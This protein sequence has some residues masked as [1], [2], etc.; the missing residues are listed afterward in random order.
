[1][2]LWELYAD[3]ERN[4]GNFKSL[5]AAYK[6]MVELKVVTPFII[7]SFANLLEENAYFEEAFKVFENGVALF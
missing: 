7:I 6:R 1:L 3:L 4:F 2:K 5:R